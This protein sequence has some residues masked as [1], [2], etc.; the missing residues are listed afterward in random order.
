MR[1]GFKGVSFRET[2][3]SEHFGR[4]DQIALITCLKKLNVSGALFKNLAALQLLR[5]GALLEQCQVVV[6]VADDLGFLGPGIPDLVTEL[7]PP[8]DPKDPAV[9]KILRRINSLSPY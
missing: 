8:Q 5:G 7:C 6:F 2:H 3:L 9:L 1:A 4:T